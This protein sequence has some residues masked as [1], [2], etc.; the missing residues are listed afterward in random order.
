M[1]HLSNLLFFGIPLLHHY[2]NLH[3]SIICCLSCGNIC[4][5]SGISLLASS[6]D[7]C[8]DFFECNSVD[9]PVISS[10]ILLPIKF[11]VAPTVF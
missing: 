3:S 8:L 2:I 6:D 9:V 5:S 4:L 10:A 11:P 1:H 7:N